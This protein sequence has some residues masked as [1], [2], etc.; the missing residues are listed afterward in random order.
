L[1]LQIDHLCGAETQKIFIADASPIVRER[2]VAMLGE[3]A[4]IEIVGQT[5]NLTEASNAIQKLRPDIVILD[6]GM[7]GDSGIDLLQSI[8]QAEATSII[9]ILTNYPYQ[10]HQQK[11]LHAGADFFLD[12]SIEFDQIPKLLE[13]FRQGFGL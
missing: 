7:P 3:L 13:R 6:I 8:K 2:L 5:E 1:T 12:K 10:R 4:G 9:I 11:C